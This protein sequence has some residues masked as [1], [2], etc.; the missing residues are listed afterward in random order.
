MYVNQWTDYCWKVNKK[1]VFYKRGS[2]AAS[3][4]CRASSKQVCEVQESH[5]GRGMLLTGPSSRGQ[6][7]TP[8]SAHSV[9][10]ETP[11]RSQTSETHCTE[12]TLLWHVGDWN[13]DLLRDTGS[14]S[15]VYYKHVW[16]NVV[17]WTNSQQSQP[18]KDV[19]EPHSGS[20]SHDGLLSTSAPRCLCGS[21]SPNKPTWILDSCLW[22]GEQTQAFSWFERVGHSCSFAFEFTH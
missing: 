10:S 20:L 12:N 17:L 1:K 8:G 7:A 6:M 18:R 2:L 19:R 4:Q 3:H 22:R 21:S 11:R 9:P 5:N 16:I 13:T 14:N 15:G